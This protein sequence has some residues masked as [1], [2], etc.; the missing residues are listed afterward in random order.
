MAEIKKRKKKK[1]KNTPFHN[2]LRVFAFIFLIVTVSAFAGDL[3]QMFRLKSE[4]SDA[5]QKLEEVQAENERLTQQRLK[6]QDSDYVESYA[7][8]NY[9]LSKSGEQIFYLPEDSSK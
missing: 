4:L 1:K 8:S 9:N 6:L 5:Q 3:Y 7:R 2:L